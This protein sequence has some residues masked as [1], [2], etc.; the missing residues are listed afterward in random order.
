MDQRRK[1]LEFS[2]REVV[3]RASLDEL[4]DDDCVWTPLRFIMRGPRHPDVGE[5][6]FLIDRKGRGCLGQVVEINGWM[7]RVR[8]DLGKLEAS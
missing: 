6:V 2:E 5:S 4:D 8:P 7:A 1:K 3:L